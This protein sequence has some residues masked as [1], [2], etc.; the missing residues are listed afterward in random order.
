MLRPTEIKDVSGDINRTKND[1]I[2]ISVHGCAGSSHEFSYP[3][4]SKK[5]NPESLS[6][7]DSQDNDSNYNTID[8]TM[9]ENALSFY[10]F[11]TSNND[12]HTDDDENLRVGDQNDDL[13]RESGKKNRIVEKFHDFVERHYDAAYGS[14]AEDLDKI[15]ECCWNENL[16]ALEQHNFLHHSFHYY[17]HENKFNLDYDSNKLIRKNVFLETT[18]KKRLAVCFRNNVTNFLNSEST[19]FDEIIDIIKEMVQASAEAYNK[20]K[21]GYKDAKKTLKQLFNLKIEGISDS[22]YSVIMNDRRNKIILKICIDLPVL[23]RSNFKEI[24][25][26]LQKTVH[27]NSDVFDKLEDIIKLNSFFDSLMFEKIK[28]SHGS[29]FLFV[30]FLAQNID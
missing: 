22:S 24:L 5:S 12:I 2:R 26:E 13:K 29:Q 28:L 11:L 19:N 14:E 9:Y 15:S 25:R 30:R 10:S 3:D 20:Y 17:Y 18:Y 4:D 8:E 23:F 1:P 16:N 7:H 6:P 21:S 27:K